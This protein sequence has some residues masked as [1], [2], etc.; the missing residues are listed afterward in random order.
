[1]VLYTGMTLHSQGKTSKKLS[2]TF[3]VLSL[4]IWG[5]DYHKAERTNLLSKLLKL[6]NSDFCLLQENSIL[7]EKTT[8]SSRVA[9]LNNYNVLEYD[10]FFSSSILYRGDIIKKGIINLDK[11]LSLKTIKT[12]SRFNIYPYIIIDRGCHRVM[13]VSVHLPWGPYEHLRIESTYLLDKKINKLIKEFDVET[14]IIGGDFNAK[15]TTD[16]IRYLEGEH[17]YKGCSTLWINTAKTLG[18]GL[19]TTSNIN[20]E[21]AI[22]VAK[23]VGIEEVA[24]LK[25]RTIDYQFTQGYKYGKVGYPQSVEFIESYRGKLLSDHVGI[26]ATYR[27]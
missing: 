14:T 22:I 23:M 7:E 2:S 19:V 20:N 21:Y 13:L 9:S 6:E 18:E 17:V 25:N 12:A 3:K 1:M 11:E 4:N 24:E 10:A 16:T 8:V 27:C 15:P 5:D 26:I